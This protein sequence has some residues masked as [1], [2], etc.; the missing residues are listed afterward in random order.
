MARTASVLILISV[1]SI[2][3]CFKTLRT[4]EESSCARCARTRLC[5]RGTNRVA[6]LADRSTQILAVGA[7]FQARV[8]RQ[9]EIIAASEAR[10]FGCISAGSAS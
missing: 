9:L 7:A 1:C 6:F 2:G 5:A 4:I 3:A 10:C 8:V